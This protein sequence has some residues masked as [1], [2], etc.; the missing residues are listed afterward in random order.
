[1]KHYSLV[2]CAVVFGLCIASCNKQEA[3]PGPGVAATSNVEAREI[4]RVR[5]TTCHGADGTGTGPGAAALNPKP[6]NYTDPAWQDA[7]KDE[8]IKHI[9]V[10]G[11]AAVGK[12]P[13]MPSNPDLR[14]KPDVVNG[15]L[16]IVRSFRK[17]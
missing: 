3:P 10:V 5:C 15:L 14:E 6:R 2:C 9:I 4:F 7:I 17:K 12:S 8:D 11:G 13:G 1:M 16:E